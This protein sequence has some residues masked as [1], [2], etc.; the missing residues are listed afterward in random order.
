MILI[1]IIA[2]FVA[3]LVLNWLFEHLNGH[4]WIYLIS[5]CLGIIVFALIGRLVSPSHPITWHIIFG[6]L[7]AGLAFITGSTI[8]AWRDHSR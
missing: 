4:G 8:F 5:A 3:I 2:F 1:P 7:V 6:I